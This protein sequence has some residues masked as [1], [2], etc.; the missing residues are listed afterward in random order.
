MARRTVKPLSRDWLFKQ[1]DDEDSVYRPVAQ[2]PTN[3]HLDLIANGLI[4]DP[5]FAKNEKEVQWV[6]EKSWVYRT[7]FAS[8]PIRSSSGVQRKVVLAFEGLDTYATV[9]LNGTEILK[10]DNMFIPERVE[11]T[12]LLYREDQML[13]VL[14][15]TFESAFLV[16]KRIPEMHPGHHW[17]CWNGDP[18]R[19]AVR[20]A[21]YHYGWD[22]GPTFLTCGPWRPINIEVYESRIADLYFTTDV[23]RS[24]RSATIIAKAD[25]EGSAKAVRFEVLLK[26]KVVN[27]ETVGVSEGTATAIFLTQNPELWYPAGYGLQSLYTLTARLLAGDSKEVDVES[28]RFGLRRANLVQRKL[29]DVPGNTFFFEINNIPL[30]CGGSNWIPADSFIPRVTEEKY[31][32][33]VKLAVDGN[34]VMIRVWGG[35]IFEEQAFY[36]A[37]D[38]MGLLVWQDF[39]FG[40]GNYP[41]YPEFLESVRRE[42]TASVKLLRHH[43][44]V[45]IYAGNNEDYQYQE[46]E[47][48]DYDPEDHDPQSWLKSS[49][50]ARYIYEKLLVDVTK[51]LVP[52]TYYHFGSPWGGKNT[53]DPTVGDIHQWN[54]WH[55]TQEKYQ[56]FDKLIGRFV[57][58]FGMEAF[59]DIETI[60]SYLPG[61]STERYPQSS[62]MDFHN[63]AAGHERRIA[64]Y[65]AENMQYQLD[66]IEQ[67]VYC[68]QLMQAECLSSAYRLWKR[69]WKGPGHEYCAGAL[70]W[71]LNDCWPVTSWAIADYYLRP[72]LAYYAVKREL[73]SLTIGLKR[74]TTVA[75]PP[76]NKYSRIPLETTHKVA[77]WATNLSTQARSVKV[78]VKAF[79]VIS[80]AEIHQAIVGENVSLPAN[81]STEITEF[82]VPIQGTDQ[83]EDAHVETVV[84]AYLHDPL[85]GNQL[86]RY[87]NWPDPLKYVPLQQPK[88]LRTKIV[89]DGEGVEVRAEVPVKGVA[90]EDLGGKKDSLVWADNGVD[91]VPGEAVVLRVKGLAVG[92]EER[93]GVRYLGF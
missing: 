88:Q 69:Q 19:L 10:T 35:G 87:V 56:D 13:N 22:W 14:E 54:V 20:K 57:S 70:V 71:Q 5:F 34:Q 49:F 23:E 53:R 39:L 41:A 33:W 89:Q 78:S 73:D 28:K 38:E 74:T 16:G 48:L 65:L 15:I 8:P 44:S 64:L 18:S 29:A 80:G 63:K 2:F 32:D 76:D 47:G 26:G 58:E 17:G 52:G 1:A 77:L 61:G 4:P 6:G 93:I 3:I 7:Q 50:P 31:R 30:F 90:L 43:P 9:V 84:A 59:P 27:T 67:F 86:A 51:E 25:V 24:L 68:T 11:V 81:R 21:Q 42:A 36:D 12:G 92:E 83:D 91:V 79:N 45:V 62:T 82:E 46:S 37:C 55:G 72:K 60:D 40:C 75:F 85:S 66:P